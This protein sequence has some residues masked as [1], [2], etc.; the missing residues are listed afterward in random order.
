MMTNGH[1]RCVARMADPKPTFVFKIKAHDH[2]RNR[3]SETVAKLVAF[4]KM[5]EKE[6]T[7]N[8]IVGNVEVELVSQA[9]A[10]TI[11][12]ESNVTRISECKAAYANFGS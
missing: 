9:C 1:S 6:M 2:P 11:D 8:D 12:L 4:A 10:S 5:I 7:D 3:P